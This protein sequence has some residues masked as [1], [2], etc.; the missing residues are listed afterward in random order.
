MSPYLPALTSSSVSS[1]VCVVTFLDG[2]VV[3]WGGSITHSDAYGTATLLEAAAF[4]FMALLSCQQRS[5][6]VLERMDGLLNEEQ[7]KR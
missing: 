6:E 1:V 5:I 7:V 3:V 2:N 4:P